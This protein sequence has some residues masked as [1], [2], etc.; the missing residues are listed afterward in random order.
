MKIAHILNHFL[1]NH[2]AGTEVYALNLGK[3][4]MANG[5]EV[6]FIIP[7]YHSAQTEEYIVDG[8]R[9][10]RYSEPS[11]VDKALQMGKRKPDGLRY[12]IEVLKEEKPD[13]VHFHELAGSNGITLHH[14]IAAKGNGFKTIMTLHLARYTTMNVAGEDLTDIFR[15]SKGSLD[16]YQQKGIRGLSAKLLYSAGVVLNVLNMDTSDSG[17]W[18]TALAVPSIVEKRK[19]DFIKLTQTCD[20][21]VTIS[22]W[23]HDALAGAGIDKEKLYFIEQGIQYSNSFT[24]PEKIR[25]GKLKLIFIGRIS[26]FKGVKNLIEVVEEL[27]E[28]HLDIYGD[29]G[30]DPSYMNSCKRILKDAD[31]IEMKGSIKPESVVPTITMYDMLILPSTIHEMSPLV[32]REAFAARVPV[33]AS[34]SNGAMEQIAEGKNGWFFK[35]NDWDDLRSKLKWLIDHPEE[36]KKAN[37]FPLVRTFE[38]VA[39]G[40][41]EVY[42]GV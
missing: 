11:R 33:L 17:K 6:I 42:G 24:Y 31:N 2:I 36:I 27:K 4:L 30:E 41:E 34:D 15:N 12:F 10:I 7:N 39:R 5:H 40:Y 13:V 29:S 35:R 32:I 20:V 38:E 18:G 3:E 22:H 37:Q 8:M 26:H 25:K 16:F 14:V 19:K 23:Y 28:V 1:P 9:V 21:I